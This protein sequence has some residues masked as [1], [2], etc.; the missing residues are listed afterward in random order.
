M[1]IALPKV[2]AG[3]RHRKRR[4]LLPAA[5]HQAWA[6]IATIVKLMKQL[7]RLMALPRSGK[8]VSGQAGI[9]GRNRASRG[10]ACQGTEGILV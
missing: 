3:M 4:R 9:D 5:C 6:S 10:P 1:G 7:R 2:V 8:E